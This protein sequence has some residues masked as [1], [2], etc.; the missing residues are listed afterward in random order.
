LLPRGRCS[1]FLFD[2]RPTDPLTFASVATVML[3]VAFAA[4][5]IPSRRALTVDP[6]TA[7]RAE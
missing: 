7:L 6:I 2:V 4:S 5:Y 1:G 3:V